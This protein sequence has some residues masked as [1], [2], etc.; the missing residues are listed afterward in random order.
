[1]GCSGCG[2]KETIGL[3]AG[4]K[5]N[6]SCSTGCGSKLDVY[7]WLLN[8]QVAG[9]SIIHDIVEVKFK[10]TRKEYFKNPYNH[11]FE[12]SD[13]VTVEASTGGWD[14]GYVSLTG[15]LVKLQ[16]RKYKIDA[17]SDMLKKVLR[18]SNDADMERYEEGKKLEQET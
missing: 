6:G 16:M 15:E 1:M 17:N 2:T 10:G 7:D 13:A 12:T 11:R 5:N 18:R 4:C 14:V 3:P 9:E 8:I